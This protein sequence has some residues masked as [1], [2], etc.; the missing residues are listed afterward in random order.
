MTTTEQRWSCW[1]YIYIRSFCHFQKVGSLC[2]DS[3]VNRCTLARSA[4]AVCTLLHYTTAV[5]KC[6]QMNY[7]NVVQRKKCMHRWPTIKNRSLAC[8]PTDINCIYMTNI[9]V[10]MSEGP[11]SE[12]MLGCSPWAFTAGVGFFINTYTEEKHWKGLGEKNKKAC[13]I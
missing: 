8:A 12:V 3:S 9:G 2:C 7:Y 11:N 4:S 1:S 13:V 10:A 6:M 5:I